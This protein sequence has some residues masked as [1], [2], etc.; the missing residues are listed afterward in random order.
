MKVVIID[1]E[2]QSHLALETQLQQQYPFVNI[3][4][5]G[6]N[7]AEGYQLIEQ[8]QPDLVFLDIEMPDG[9]GFDLLQ[10][11]GEV[12]FQVIFVTAHNQ[13]ARRA[14]KFGALDYLLKPVISDE[15][16]EAIGRAQQKIKQQISQKQLELM[17]ETFQLLQQKKLPTRL[18]IST[19]EG[20]IYKQVKHIV[21][22]EAK[23][24]YTEFTFADSPK[25]L[26]ASVN[27]GEYEEQF[28]PYEEFMR[29]H[30]SHL[31][32]LKYV[33]RFVKQ[34]GGYLKMNNKDTLKITKRIQSKLEVILGNI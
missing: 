19:S 34:G 1:D 28:A 16:A 12:A 17:L 26:L 11:F 30:R 6:Y 14:I 31:V 33:E 7:V 25:K 27:L 23:Q 24:N 18:A 4:G 10:K 21:R 22:L 29:V 32:N 2:P 5:K 20:I 15:L 13:Y 8:Y 3:M 9:T